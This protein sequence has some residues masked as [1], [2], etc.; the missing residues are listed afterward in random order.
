M[1]T[2]QMTLRS[3]TVRCPHC[4]EYYSVTYKYC[5][6]CDAGRQ[7]EERRQAEKKK[8]RQSMLGGIFG[9]GKEPEKKKRS[10]DSAHRESR[11]AR[12]ERPVREDRPARDHA[13]QER[14]R[15]E[16]AAPPAK[17][18]PPKKKES[19]FHRET[20]RKTSELTEEEKAIR[21][22]EREA[23]AAQ[24]KRERDRAAR[25]AA[26]A[27]APKVEAGP[28]FE[29]VTVPETFGYPETPETAADPAAMTQTPVTA[30]GPVVL[31]EGGE[32]VPV[33][34]I[35]E[36]PE[37]AA[38]AAEPAG[39]AAAPVQPQEQP[40]EDEAERSRWEF[41]R[42]LEMVPDAPVVEVAGS[43]QPEAAAPQPET[44]AQPAPQSQQAP[45][46]KPVETEEDLDALLSE[47]RDMLAES[48]VP[49]LSPDQLKKPP[50]PVPQ[51][52]IPQTPEA[53]APQPETA[54]P[55]VQPA[56][57]AVPQPEEAP[58]V[59][60]E[61]P[62]PPAEEAPEIPAQPEQEAPTIVVPT[63]EI[64]AQLAEEAAQ[65]QIEEE[66]AAD[67]GYHAAFADDAP[68]QVIHLEDQPLQ[69]LENAGEPEPTAVPQPARERRPREQ[70]AA[71]KA[72]SGKSA[73]K[74]KKKSG[75][76]PPVLL[77]LSLVIIVAAIVIVAKTVVPAFQDGLFSNSQ[78]A[79]AESLI[80]D[81]TEASLTE[82]GQTL[83]LVA[84]FA[85]E[86][87]SG[88]V[89]WSSSDEAIATVDQTGLVTAVAP[90]SVT[91]TA[92]LENGQS[93]Q[94]TVQC[95]W[96]DQ[97]G[98]A[99]EGGEQPAEAEAP[100]GPALSVKDISLDSQGATKQIQVTG[101]SGAVKWSSDNT[102][103]ATVADDGTVTAVD[104]GTATVT[105]EVDGKKL[106][107][108]VRCIW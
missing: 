28:V 97:A 16:H 1:E 75:G 30:E 86:G 11:P 82:Q 60:Q 25:E 62:V 107:C 47:I 29:E 105:A 50:Q 69:I 14:P 15:K 77:I 36:T 53:P 89:T 87:S 6:F 73:K 8:Q 21:L 24:R 44:P 83:T 33:F 35:P 7:E 13:A 67:A 10:G 12:E 54:A 102:A 72:E 64:S 45:Q 71:P 37:P 19:L 5:P 48:P 17:K 9:G 65:E 98:A 22:A 101:A 94:C 85:P 84:T 49:Q 59:T 93:A 80:L 38:P 46:E 79:D 68:T 61:A 18:A 52:E 96:G 63:A 103:V 20:R 76:R 4:G 32:E 78:T 58:T 106:N 31:P 23:R 41:L 3:Q 88:A 43:A 40:P 51:A 27:A 39:E 91:I 90:G 92:A 34:T 57:E 26:L 108:E 74:T 104:K 56:P 95:A 66:T 99:P 42:E 81:Q 100:A 2:K 55:E 70:K